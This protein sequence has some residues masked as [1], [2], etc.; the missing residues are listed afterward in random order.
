MVARTRRLQGTPPKE[1]K[2]AA[3]LAS[4]AAERIRVLPECSHVVAVTIKP[5]APIDGIDRWSWKLTGTLPA[6]PS[7]AR[8]LAQSAVGELAASYVLASS[9]QPGRAR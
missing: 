9:K 2:T 7:D 1:T 3:E 5:V 8:S 4:L 6:L